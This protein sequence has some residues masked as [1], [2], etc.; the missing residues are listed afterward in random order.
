[1]SESLVQDRNKRVAGN[2]ATG[3]LKIIALLFMFTDHAGKMLFNNMQELRIIGRIAFPLYC[4]CMAV[5]AEY[6]RSMPKYLLRILAV[7]II[8][9][10]LYMLALGHPWYE[11]NIFLTLLLGLA[12]IW[13]IREKKYL[14]Q[15]WAPAAVLILATLLQVDYG[16]KGVALI[17]LMYACRKSNGAIAAVTVSFALY[18]GSGYRQIASAFGLTLTLAGWPE[19]ISALIAPFLRIQALCVLALPFIL[20]P[21]KK[22]VKLPKWTGYGLYPAHLLVLWIL[23]KIIL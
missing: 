14:S 11:P 12:G 7:G 16:W 22:D 15:I 8:S 21:F 5:G 19:C 9:Q 10:P 13:G 17:L 18:W 3:L 1:M 4:W 2:T 6:T 23:E 20:I